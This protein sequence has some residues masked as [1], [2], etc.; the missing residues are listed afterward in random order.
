MMGPINQQLIDP[1][2]RVIRKLR[3]SLTDRCNLRCRYCMPP[4]AEFLSSDRYLQP[5]EYRDI[6]AE[7][8]ELGIQQ[9][10]LTGGE[11]LLRREFPEIVTALATI[12]TI[13]LSLTTNGL[14]LEPHLSLLKNAGI[15]KLN[16]SLDS[17]QAAT[18]HRI[19]YGHALER[20]LQAI[21][22]AVQQGFQVKLNMVV[23]R[24]WNDHELVDMVAYGKQLGVEVRFL[25]LMRVGYACQLPQNAFISAQEMLARLQEHYQ[26]TSIP[27]PR[28][29]T[30]FRFRTSCGAT[31]GFIASESQP[32]CGHC[33]RWRLSADG[34]LR[35][36]LFREGGIALR[37]MNA[38][39]RQQA[40]QQLLG[41]K[42]A[43]RGQTV[44]H[45]MYQIGG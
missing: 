13:E 19:T 38:Q 4:D 8:A 11:P 12:P 26:L 9:V 44:S 17:L 28:D 18:F 21:A 7:L 6:V 25:E 39:Q 29:S 45:A 37:G 2:G 22:Q 10:R 36:C 24:G 34:I 31:I 14:L 43:V 40:Y 27:S 42:P 16:I 20:V 33:S 15:H 23:M 3:L 1:Q 35:A 32:F 30:A 5:N 41:M